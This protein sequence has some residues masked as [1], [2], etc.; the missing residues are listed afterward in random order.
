MNL[1][2]L[3]AADHGSADSAILAT[4]VQSD[5]KEIGIQVEIFSVENLTEYQTEGNFDFLHW[6]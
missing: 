6:K 5:L 3:Q 4:A 1:R 2:Y